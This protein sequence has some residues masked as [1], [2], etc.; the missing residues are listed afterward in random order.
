MLK[1]MRKYATGYMIKAIFG[2]I[3]IVFI[4]W[5]V[6][7]LKEGDTTVAEVGPHKVSLMEYQETYSRLLNMY[8]SI[9][10]DKFDETTVKEL[11]LKE[12]TMED[13]VDRY[14]LLDQA[15]ELGLKVSD[16]EF[17]DYLNGI[18]AFKSDGKFNK[19]QYV[20]LLKRQ[21]LDPQRFEESERA[22]MLNQKIMNLIRDN[23]S[24]VSNDQVWK[25]YVKAKGKVDLAY[26]VF[27]PSDNM[28]K[29]DV[30]EKELEE[31]YEK[32]KGTYIG[33]NRYGLKYIAFDE[34]SPVKDDA[35]YLD[36]IKVKD[37]DKY[38]KEKDLTVTDLGTMRESEV[39]Q[40][41]KNMKPSEWLRGLKKGDISL[42]I[43]AD[44][45]SYIFQVSDFEVGKPMD[46]AAVLKVLREKV[47]DEKAKNLTK[48]EAEEVIAKKGFTSKSDTGF[49]SRNSIEIPGI[50]PVPPEHAGLLAL[51]KDLPVYEKPVEIKGKYYVFSFKDEKAPDAAEW[52][53]DKAGFKQY[54]VRKSG[55]DFFKSFMDDLKK[56]SKVKIN[57]KE[58]NVG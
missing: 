3:I 13:I 31:R 55:D 19:K 5:G 44:S 51:S 39:A 1:F 12:R 24:F 26:M 32:E 14:L 41:L 29:V 36:L 52:E 15:K 33:E 50:G 35:A 23:G 20:E 2:L 30:N 38:G 9:L 27:N 10:K 45:K 11:K 49:L 57:W 6:G 18:D 53:K 43:R 58:I 21:G 28:K 25:A 42:P 16:Q 4:F 56:K 8:R 7:G 48:I 54:M 34:K 22:A 40:K 47:L 37:I 17:S 46:K